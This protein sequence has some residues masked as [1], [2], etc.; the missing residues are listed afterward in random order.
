[1]F[2]TFADVVQVE[3]GY[4]WA[5]QFCQNVVQYSGD[6]TP[7]PVNVVPLLAEMVTQWNTLVKAYMPADLSFTQIKA[8]DLSSQNG[9]TLFYQTGLPI[10]G[11]SAGASLPNNCAVVITKRTAQRGRSYRG[12]IYQPGLTELHTTGNTVQ[13]TPVAAF[14]SFWDAMKFHAT[15]AVNYQMVIASRYQSGNQLPVGVATPVTTLTSDGVVDSQ[16]R[17]LPG[18]GN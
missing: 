16:R 18:R 10:A 3:L 8:I 2:T 7:T 9:W 6:V 17:R 1:V 12:R 5:G 13:G 14:V 4:V 15:G 11:T